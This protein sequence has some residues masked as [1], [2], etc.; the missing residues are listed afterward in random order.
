MENPTPTIE[1]RPHDDKHNDIHVS[2]PGTEYKNSFQGPERTLYS[3]MNSPMVSKCHNLI[4]LYRRA[5]QLFSG[6]KGREIRYNDKH[7]KF[8]ILRFKAG[9]TIATL[10]VLKM[11]IGN[12]DQLPSSGSSAYLHPNYHKGIVFTMCHTPRDLLASLLD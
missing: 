5:A 2:S 12:N 10:L 8:R 9:N 1:H 3:Y 6:L 4:Y 7:M 11:F